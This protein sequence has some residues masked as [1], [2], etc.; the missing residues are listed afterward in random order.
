MANRP[1]PTGDLTARLLPSEVVARL[2]E[3]LPKVA[4][5]AL[6]E[7]TTEIPEYAGQ[8]RGEVAQ[9]IA[10]AITLAMGVFLRLLDEDA[11]EDGTSAPLEAARQ[12]AYDLGRGEAKSGRTADALLAAYRIGARV[13]WQSMSATVVEAGVDADVV[14]RFAALMFAYIDDLSASSVA[15]HTDQLARSGR[16][17]EQRREQL[18]KA[19]LTGA[20]ETRLTELAEAADWPVPQTLTAVLVPSSRVREALARLEPDTLNIPADEVGVPVSEPLAVLLVPDVVRTRARLLD[21]LDSTAVLGPGRPWTRARESLDIAVRAHHLLDDARGGDGGAGGDG[22]G[23]DGDDGAGGAGA[24]GDV[25]DGAL[26]TADH[27]DTLVVGADLGALADLRASILAPLATLTPGAAERL[28]ETL[29][30]WLT[31]LGRRGEV[32]E[33]LHIHP[34][35]VRYRMNQLRELYGDRLD[36]PRVVQQL[37]IALS[38]APPE[39]A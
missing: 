2:Q 6:A 36:D 28:T 23:G 10:S 9:I 14:A 35:T 5:D 39:H 31:H 25:R 17:R 12:G 26:D 38:L 1:M 21:L 4:E 16:V 34:Q 13:S 18:T 19:L 30:A 11:S 37:V 15:G 3:D 22:A 24:G 20:R 33:A 27:L 8:W 29:H 32:A 7:V